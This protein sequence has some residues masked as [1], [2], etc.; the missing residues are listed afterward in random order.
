MGL[1]NRI[2]S[3]MK[4]RSGQH[5]AGVALGHPFDQMFERADSAARDYWHRNCIGNAAG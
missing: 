5:C 4:D 2:G 3:E 1:G